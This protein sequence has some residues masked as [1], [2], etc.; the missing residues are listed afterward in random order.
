[1]RIAR[2]GLALAAGLLAASARA[3]EAALLEKIERLERRIEE[4]EGR[5]EPTR[6]EPGPAEPVPA[7]PG[8]AGPEGFRWADR[9]RLSGSADTGYFDGQEDTFFDPGSFEIWDARLFVDAELGDAVELGGA[10]LLRNLGL[11]FEWD[12]VRI[13][14]LQNQVGELYVDFQGVL[15]SSWL[16]FQVGRFQ[17]PVGENYLRFSQGYWRNP[18]VTNTVGGPWWWDEGVRAYGSTPDGRLGYVASVSDGETPFN[19]DRDAD[20]QGT[21]KLFANPT[22]WL[23]LS[24][25]GLGSGQ[26]GS[27][28]SPAM[29]ALWLGESWAR[30]FGAGTA[31]PNFS[32][33]VAVPDGPNTLDHTWLV[34]GDAIAAFPGLGQLWLAYGRYAIDSDGPGLYDRTLQYWIA[35]LLL[36]GGLVAEVLEPFTLGLRA[37][38]LGTY[39]S[40]EG[41]LLDSRYA[42]RLGYN[43]ESITAYSAVLGWHL[44]R[45]VALRA[46]FTHQDIGL[47]SGVTPE[48]RGAARDA[49]FFALEVGAHF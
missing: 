14:S 27:G 32:G 17:I 44:W 37:D 45:T 16:G 3:D 42:S 2:S 49:D 21:L 25:S 46:Q 9:V 8:L 22:P 23:H 24:A 40:D 20:V 33:G 36:E 34:A 7:E 28:S 35:E 31:L 29:G 11:T 39:D 5:L 15:D 6:A 26:I 47:V 4:L 12:L 43:M 38:G 1:V 48:M 19:T 13:G 10:R 41:Y 30:A 18:F